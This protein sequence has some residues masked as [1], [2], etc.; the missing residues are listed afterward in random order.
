MKFLSILIFLILFAFTVS[1]SE[2]NNKIILKVENNIVTNYEFKNKILRLLLLS[3]TEINQKNINQIKKPALNSL[4]INELKKIELSKYPIEISSSRLNAFILDISSI[5]IEELKNKF[6]ENNIDY[7]LYVDEIETDLKWQSLI[8]NKFSYKINIDEDMIDSEVSRILQNQAVIEEFNLSEIEIPLEIANKKLID[9]KSFE[10]REKI[11]NQ[12]F[13]NVALSH[14]ISLSSNNKGN[15]G[16][17][18]GKSLSKEIL[19]IVKKMDIGEVSEPILQQNNLIFLKL[20]K[21][22]IYSSKEINKE[23]LKKRVLNEKKNE[24]FNLYSRS[25]LSKLKN[26]SLIE[27]K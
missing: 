14:S 19:N 5:S 8:F 2:I 12:G 16:W 21:K 26:N 13:E 24:L 22:K 27:Y 20:N 1:S 7:D 11:D 6:K 10:I 18:N 4:L 25:Y 23:D 15:L 3:N 17:I 9:E